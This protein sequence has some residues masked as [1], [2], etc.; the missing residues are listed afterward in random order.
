MRRLLEIQKRLLPDLN[1]QLRK[2]Y[3]I[4]QQIGLSRSIGRRTLAASLGWTERVLRAETNFLK[5]QGLLTMEAS[6][7]RLTDE[8]RRIVEEIEPIV[9]ELFGLSELEEQLR[10]RYGLRQVTVVVGDCDQSPL[11]KAE[12]GRAAAAALRKYAVPEGIVAVTGGTT[13]AQVAEQLVA[14][15]QLKGTL[16]VPARG[17]LGE[18]VELQANTIASAMAKRT[19]GQY[20]MLHVP[21]HLSEDAYQTLM[22]EPNIREIVE[23]IR[24]ARIVLHGIGEA[25]VMAR[26]RQVPQETCEA[27]LAEGAHAEAFGYYFNRKGGVVH[28]MPTVGLRL[29]DIDAMDTVIGVAGGASKGPAIDAIM[30]SGHTDVLITDEAAA[31]AILE[32]QDP[33]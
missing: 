27:L 6:G 7:M 23:L 1:E 21:D 16:F 22:Q 19:G 29:E 26:R 3:T 30:R 17:G 9:K 10:Q 2:R 32:Q 15:P 11:A 5:E 12:L 25:L 4:L 31:R 33:E 8:G 20:R 24:R 18:R 28:K 14:S 13:M